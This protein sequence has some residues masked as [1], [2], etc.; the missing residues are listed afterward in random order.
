MEKVFF[1]KTENFSDSERMIRKV[2]FEHYRIRDAV[3]S[4]SETG[5]PFL[6][7]T[8]LFF[9]VTHTK[10][11][12]F[13]AV[14]DE[15]IGIDA[16]LISREIDYRPILSRFPFDEREEI[17]G[18]EDF[19]HH[20]TAIESTVKWLGGSLAAELKKISFIGGKIFYS[21]LELPVC[22]SV[23]QKDG[24]IVTLCREKGCDNTEFLSL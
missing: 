21:G 12:R 7:N 15:N 19:L 13:I 17:K 1:A 10:E 8:P 20:W 22:I 11:T 23:Y 3:I 9:S 2:F 18:K 4:R 14:S 16:E 6:E 24:H 5:K